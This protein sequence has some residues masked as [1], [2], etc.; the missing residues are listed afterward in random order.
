MKLFNL[1]F[2][3]KFAFGQILVGNQR[4]NYGCV[5][6]GGFQ[7]CETTQSCI[8]PWETNCLNTIEINNNCPD[9]C[10]PIP[11]CPRP[12]MPNINIRNCKITT[13]KDNCGCTIGCPSYDCSNLN[14]QTDID[15]QINQFCRITTSQYPQMNG[16]RLQSYNCVDKVGINET[17]GGFTPPE[18]QN[19]CLDELECVNIM[20]TMIADAPGV[21][22]E[23]CNINENRDVD[24]NCQ[25]QHIT[26]P[27]NCASWFD[28]CNTCMIDVNGNI[29]GCT[30]MYCFRQSTSQCISY[31]RNNL[32]N[33]NDIC[34]QYC[35]DKSLPNINKRNSCPQ[36]TICSTNNNL[37]G[38]DNCGNMALRCITSH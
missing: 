29:G 38:F 15:C 30:M 19:R 2:F 35:E 24:G 6:D 13:V 20:D 4:D 33:I 36:D 21:C 22:K 26:I 18:F 28:G 7:W 37:V 14:C 5:L 23:R 32:L 27:L 11:P 16:R 17:C 31:Y 12:Y 10:L 9:S 1:I 34:Y 25:N 3:V 8:R